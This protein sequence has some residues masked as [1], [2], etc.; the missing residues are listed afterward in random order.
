MRRRPA[1]VYSHQLYPVSPV[2]IR[3]GFRPEPGQR[4]QT[5]TQQGDRVNPFRVDGGACKFTFAGTASPFDDVPEDGIQLVSSVYVPRGQTGFLKGLRVAPF[6]PSFL[7][8]MA[9]ER[10]EM[11]LPDN[12][13]SPTAIGADSN[14]GVWTTPFGWE[15]YAESDEGGIVPTLWHWHLRFISGRLRDV[16]RFRNIPLFSFFDPL[17]WYLIP[18]LPVPRAAYP[19][20]IPGSS[21]GSPWGRQRVQRTGQFAQGPLQVLVPEDTTLALFVEWSQA[22]YSY[23]TSMPLNL[24]VVNV[25]SSFYPLL[26]S[27]GTLLGYT[28]PSNR[29]TAQHNARS[30]FA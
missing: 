23:K 10:L 12:N 21:P 28:S 27:F 5:P 22:L 26:P 30:W 8:S 6:K 13:Y 18:D 1:N 9:G 2:P 4:N 11:V 20:G 14:F 19:F 15:C 25:S 17:S 24:S 3:G 7:S 29:A 16:R